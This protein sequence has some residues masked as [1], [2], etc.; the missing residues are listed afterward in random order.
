VRAIG[1]GEGNP[2]LDGRYLALCDSSRMFV[3]DMDPQPPH[4]PY[5]NVRIGPVVDFLADCALPECRLGWVSVSP[6]G[7]YVVCKYG[8]DY[9]RVYD[10][11]AATLALTP[12]AL[13]EEAPRCHGTAAQGFLYDL[14]HCDMTLNPFDGN[15]DVLIGQEHCGLRGATIDGQRIGGV[16]MARLRDGAITPLTDPANEAYPHHVST[17]N[18]E[19]PGW[20]YVGYY[21]EPGKRFSDEI[22]A[23]KLDG[24]RA[25]E[26]WA[27]KHS[28]T[29]DCYRCEAHAVPSRDG[30]RV[31]WASNWAI[32]CVDCG[33]VT[34][35]KPYVVDA[36]VDRN[37]GADWVAPVIVTADASASWDE[38]GDIASYTFDFGDGSVIG[39]T[40]EP[41]AS[42]TYHEGDWTL[43]VTV[44]DAQGLAHTSSTLV[45]VASPWPNLIANPSFETSTSGWGPNAALSLAQAPGGRGGGACLEVRGPAT[46]ATFGANDS[47]NAITE[48]PAA[49]ARY[50][51]SAWVRSD[52]SRGQGKLRVREYLGGVLQGATVYS[53]AVTLSPDW[54]LV[55]VDHVALQSGSTIDFQVVDA[56]VAASES[57]QIDDVAA[58]ALPAGASWS[59][60][61][62]LQME[63]RAPGDAADAERPERS[64]AA[65]LFPNP[66]GG[67][68]TLRWLTTRPGPCRIDIHDLQGRVV[69]RLADAADLEPGR[70]D[71]EIGR[72]AGGDRLRSGVYFYRVRAA[73]GTLTGRFLVVD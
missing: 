24:S 27:H 43:A 23:V 68:G 10:L 36:R 72:G 44:T 48:V 16:V 26:R 17:Q 22:V 65:R 71:L 54:Q 50:R 29:Q 37:T 11:D 9:P 69:R 6:S 52:S 73:E 19:R 45:H 39:P 67:R 15:E 59:V 12:R 62:D 64:F 25:V 3:V 35:L 28:A 63:S 7:K 4:A 20:A 2:S 60:E 55:T 31:V 38:D 18:V 47:P 70:H 41:R 61:G 57:F 56:P 49:G 8:G 46:T 32:D 53:S 34:D 14:G 40:S 13:P 58:V 21:P 42:H 5:P 66:M 51:F 33:P 1:D 30:R